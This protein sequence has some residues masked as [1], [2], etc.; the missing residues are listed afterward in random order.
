[1]AKA[2]KK[3]EAADE[4]IVGKIYFI[5]DKKIML[6]KETLRNFTMQPQEI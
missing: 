5:R 6:D 4:E 2:V 1:M 3:I